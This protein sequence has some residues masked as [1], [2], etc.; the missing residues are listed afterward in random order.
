M[1]AGG[2]ALGTVAAFITSVTGVGG[3]VA[4]AF[5]AVFTVAATGSLIC[6]WNGRGVN[7]HLPNVGGVW[8]TPR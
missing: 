3:V 1:L 5:A 2:A 4:G 6:N 7:I 8:C